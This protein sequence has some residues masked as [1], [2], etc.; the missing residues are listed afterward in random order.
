MHE[1]AEVPTSSEG[2]V[3]NRSEG[4]PNRRSSRSVLPE[5]CPDFH[6][7]VQEPPVAK[8]GVR[9]LEVLSHVDCDLTIDEL[10]DWLTSKTCWKHDKTTRG[11]GCEFIISAVCGFGA[12]TTQYIK[13]L[14]AGKKTCSNPRTRGLAGDIGNF[15][16]CTAKLRMFVRPEQSI[17][18]IKVSVQKTRDESWCTHTH[19]KA[20]SGLVCAALLKLDKTLE[21]QNA[22]TKAAESD[23]LSS[24]NGILSKASMVIKATNRRNYNRT[25]VR[26]N[27]CKN[28]ARRHIA[29]ARGYSN[30]PLTLRDVMD[31]RE[32]LEKEFLQS[33]ALGHQ[34]TNNLVR[35]I[36]MDYRGPSVRLVPGES[37]EEFV[38]TFTTTNLIRRAE[39]S[40]TLMIDATF[41]TN[42]AGF[43]IIIAGT[44]DAKNCFRLISVS[45]VF[46]ESKSSYTRVFEHIAKF[47]HQTSG[48]NYQPKVVMA[49]GARCIT[50]S[51]KEVFKRSPPLRRNCFFHVKQALGR[52]ISFSKKR[53]RNPQ[54]YGNRF[55][56]DL[57]ILAGAFSQERFKK[58][59][60]ALREKWHNNKKYWL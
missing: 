45:L 40:D 14:S 23:K 8:R 4:G 49:D 58:L 25:L 33:R 53:L 2:T 56:A 16:L 41:K 10:K 13:D 17:R 30:Q 18:A 47:L 54:F 5:T 35:I 32:R 46:N 11:T 52:S 22:I 44:T 38:A 7:E 1:S 19:G 20:E 21:V 51:A 29:K 24:T 12:R 50:A 48:C 15:E 27:K 60:S 28:A 55:L 26:M 37:I 3:D 39:K 36:G 31:Q 57:D 43:P 6:Y 9:Y 59:V 34:D 42:T